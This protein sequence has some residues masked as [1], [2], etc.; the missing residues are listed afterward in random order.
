[1]LDVAIIGAGLA[2][3]HCGQQLQAKGLKVALFDKSRGIGGR[4]ATRR[5]ADQS[6]D[7]GLSYWEIGGEHT[8]ALTKKLT[9][10]G[11][12]QSWSVATTASV[13]PK[14][15]Q[16]LVGEHRWMAP[17][18]MTAIAKYLAQDLVIHRG[19]Q[20]TTL[21][22][23]ANHWVLTFAQ[24]ETVTAKQVVLALPLPQV[25]TL[26]YSFI[27]VRDRPPEVFYDPALSLMVGYGGLN[28]D[29]PWQGLHLT[30]HP[31][32]RTISR[33]GEKRSPSNMTLVCQT[34]GSFASAY[35]D[36]ADLAPVASQLLENLQTLFHLPQP[37]WWQ[38]HRWRYAI[39]KNSS[40]QAYYRFS[41]SVPLL[42]CGDWC[43]GHGIEGA[44]ASGL[45]TATF[46]LD[47]LNKPT[48]P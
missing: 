32:W 16:T 30:K 26:T 27:T 29:F 15:W 46:L 24:G 45:A 28:L 39:P 41:T 8:A 1:M 2:G 13:D 47:S 11:L 25:I 9:A 33:E 36:R 3:I 4:L 38:I 35:L 34:T 22:P 17:D 20:L 12:L 19:Q 42:A 10:L 18:G 21:Q 5:V 6:L 37:L 7:H 40:G 31:L 14:D 48:L 23:M 44:I 43:F